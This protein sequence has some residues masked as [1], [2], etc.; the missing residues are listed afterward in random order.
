MNKR[1]GR[2]QVSRYA[3]LTKAEKR[4]LL[5]GKSAEWDQEDVLYWR[6]A[7]DSVRGQTLYRLLESGKYMP[8]EWMR[9]DKFIERGR[10]FP[11]PGKKQT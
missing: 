8:K 7:S 5:I 9:D 6:N 3:D 4:A 11:P 2:E 1:L 10:N